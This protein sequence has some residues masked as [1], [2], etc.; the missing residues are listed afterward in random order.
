MQ[1]IPLGVD[2]K[3]LK[4]HFKKAGS[5]VYASVSCDPV[6]KQSK[7]HGIVQYETTNEANHAL[8]TLN[9]VMLGPS[10]LQ[11]RADLQER[12]SADKTA[13]KKT[14]WSEQP[15]KN[16]KTAAVSAV[17]PGDQPRDD[18]I[19]KREIKK[20]ER[21]VQP[22]RAPRLSGKLSASTIF[23]QAEKEEEEEVIAPGVTKEFLLKRRRLLNLLDNVENDEEEEEEEVAVK[24]VTASKSPVKV[25]ASEPVRAVRA[26]VKVKAAAAKELSIEEEEE[27]EASLGQHEFVRIKKTAA[28]K[29]AK[30]ASG[31][32]TKCAS[33]VEMI[34]TKEEA[35]IQAV[36][37]EREALRNKK[38]FEGA[39]E[40]RMAL[41]R[42][43]RVQLDDAKMTWRVLPL[44][45]EV[46][47][48]NPL[49]L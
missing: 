41:R 36:V 17:R 20:V 42:E 5:V 32:W 29:A 21:E 2:W 47:P 15:Q 46:T 37:M 1:N 45:V 6:T 33:M 40:I 43:R 24:A 19:K 39:D 11:L 23:P 12:R 35:I 27:L 44:K 10:H 26:E 7:G 9:N 8:A 30:K 49:D 38:E 28:L 34:S 48:V 14:H 3:Q 31:L 16:F 13:I 25:A 22:E 4:D 18:V